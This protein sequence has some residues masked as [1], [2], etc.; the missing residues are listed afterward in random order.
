MRVINIKY[1]LLGLIIFV[2]CLILTL[3]LWSETNIGSVCFGILSLTIFIGALDYLINPDIKANK[4]GIKV[5][6]KRISWSEVKYFDNYSHTDFEGW[7]EENY[8]IYANEID[9]EKL[10]NY[11]KEYRNNSNG[12]YVGFGDEEI[13]IDVNLNLS[14]AKK[15]EVL[16]KLNNMKLN[17]K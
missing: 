1:I 14:D 11:E 5:H 2:I 9:K 16:D 10:E 13:R 8:N 3:I 15:I 6:H 12:I 17:S 7:L 4:N